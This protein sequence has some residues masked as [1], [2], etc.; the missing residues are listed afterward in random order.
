MRT[1]SVLGGSNCTFR[2]ILPR[3]QKMCF[4]TQCK[5][6]TLCLSFG[7]QVYKPK[8]FLQT[9]TPRKPETKGCGSWKATSR[10]HSSQNISSWSQHIYYYYL[11]VFY[12]KCISQVSIWTIHWLF[13]F[14][15]GI[16]INKTIVQTSSYQTVPLCS[17]LK[18]LTISTNLLSLWRLSD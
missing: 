13:S 12:F 14:F 7:C 8:D 6:R 5:A 1:Q 15:K 16:K 4:P 18:F 3:Q 17:E 9:T 11:F 10:V 2:N